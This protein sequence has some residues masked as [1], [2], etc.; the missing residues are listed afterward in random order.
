MKY[1]EQLTVKR[2]SIEWD[3]PVP[4]SGCEVFISHFP[5]DTFEDRLIPLFSAVGP[6]WEFRL[7]M[8]FSGQTRGFAYAKYGTRALAATAVSQLHGHELE[9][10][11]YLN[12]RHSTEKRQ[13]CVGELPA[14][15]EQPVL[16]RVGLGKSLLELF[17]VH[18]LIIRDLFLARRWC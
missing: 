18:E 9:P 16:Q 14:N 7:M 2:L 13:L 6:L 12:V 5:R 4:G 10:G 15:T 11:I 17:L 8:N 1:A 3:G